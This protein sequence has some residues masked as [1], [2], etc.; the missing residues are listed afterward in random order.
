MYASVGKKYEILQSIGDCI[1]ISLRNK[2]SCLICR[3][4]MLNLYHRLKCFFWYI[5]TSPRVN[6]ISDMYHF[7]YANWYCISS[8]VTNH[9]QS[10]IIIISEFMH[11]TSKER[12]A[13]QIIFLLESDAARKASLQ[14]ILPL[15]NFGRFT[16]EY[17]P[18]VMRRRQ[19]LFSYIC[20][21]CQLHVH[22]TPSK[23]YMS[24]VPLQCKSLPLKPCHIYCK[25]SPTWSVR[26]GTGYKGRQR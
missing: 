26:K 24:A 16:C 5:R 13:A 9:Q 8:Q 10:Y 1:N 21:T 19:F 4:Y 25:L 2:D 14:S 17:L 6:C 3:L 12:M 18:N 11:T 7:A 15:C 23:E 22:T 20:L